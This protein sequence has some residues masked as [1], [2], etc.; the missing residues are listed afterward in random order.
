MA[1][2]IGRNVS[3]GIARETTRSTIPASASF[4]LR[5]DDQSVQEKYDMAQQEF[6]VGVI[7]GKVGA[8]INKFVAEVDLKGPVTDKSIG[9]IL[10]S[11]LGTVSTAANTPQTGVY[12]H[13]F[14]VLQSAQH[15][16]VSVYIDDPA[17]AVD[18]AHGNCMVTKLELSAALGKHLAY[19]LGLRGKKGITQAATPAFGTENLFRP[20]D[21]TFKHAANLAG[22]G[23]AAAIQL[24]AF[25]V[26]I[27]KNIEDDDVLGS[28]SSADFYNKQML[29]TGT[30]EAIFQNE[31]DFKTAALAGTAKAI[32][33]AAINTS[34]T[35]GASANPALT[36]D[37]AKAM[38]T[39]IA[40]NRGLNDIITQTLSFEGYFSQTDAA[41]ITAVLDTTQASY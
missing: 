18:Y 41:S 14:S 8:D 29:I 33:L 32:R 1:K 9:L 3:V 37:L 35:I 24:K 7:E 26:A 6:G 20:Q 12:R 23:A 38:F 27:E 4:W 40:V 30:I 21:I 16:S 2:A 25:S 17:A 10:Y 13:T 34:A 5:L 28:T 15:P 36:I 31:S 19:S 39:E 11:T 22:L